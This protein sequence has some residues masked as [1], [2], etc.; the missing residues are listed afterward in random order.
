MIYLRVNYADGTVEGKTLNVP[1]KY[2][3]WG[4]IYSEPCDCVH[5]LHERGEVVECRLM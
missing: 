2:V 3:R 4:R 5:T 1:L